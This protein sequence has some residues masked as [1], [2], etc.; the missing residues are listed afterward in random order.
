MV[1]PGFSP[2]EA[3]TPKTYYFPNYLLKTHE[4]GRRFS[5]A[6][7][8]K[9]A[10]SPREGGNQLR[11]VNALVDLRGDAR[12]ALG[13]KFFRFHADFRKFGKIIY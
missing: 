12:D 5:I 4:N 11:F 6:N 13:I 3:P 1:D 9:G 7:P 8:G 2:G 10:N